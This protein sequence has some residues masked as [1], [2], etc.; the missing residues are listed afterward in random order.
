MIE[1][2]IY[3]PNVADPASVHK[4][5]DSGYPRLVNSGTD[6]RPIVAAVAADDPDT[7]AKIAHPKTLTCNNRPGARPSHGAKPENMSWLS[8]DLNRIS[9]IKINNGKAANGQLWL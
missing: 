9:P 4:I 8:R 1:G 7:A 6:I 3:N 2:G 5:N